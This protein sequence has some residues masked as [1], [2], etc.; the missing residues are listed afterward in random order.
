M[1]QR[2]TLEGYGKADD[3]V[4]AQI[5]LRFVLR[6]LADGSCTSRVV[7]EV[8][9]FE[10]YVFQQVRAWELTTSLLIGLKPKERKC[11]C[12]N[13]RVGNHESQLSI[14][15]LPLVGS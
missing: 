6:H 5:G 1:P 3:T 13:S 11:C 10:G 15:W 4:V 7:S 2:C 9:T 14:N 12:L 8:E